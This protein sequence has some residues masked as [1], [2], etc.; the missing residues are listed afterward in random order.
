MYVVDCP[1]HSVYT[2]IYA[3]FVYIGNYCTSILSVTRNG[4]GTVKERKGKDLA[5]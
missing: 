4:T 2:Y 1:P 5:S 3:Y